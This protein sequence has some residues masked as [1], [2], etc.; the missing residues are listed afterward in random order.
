MIKRLTASFLFECDRCGKICTTD[1]F[2][3]VPMGYHEV[4]F[5]CCGTKIERHGNVCNECLK[6]FQDLAER[7]FDEAN[8][9]DSDGSKQ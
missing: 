4:K 2:E 5:K 6:D 9:G 7:F 3:P 8:K 1:E